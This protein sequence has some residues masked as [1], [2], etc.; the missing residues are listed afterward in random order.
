MKRVAAAALGLVVGGTVAAN[1]ADPPLPILHERV[2]VAVWSW[3]GLYAGTHVG[4]GFGHTQF[5]RQ[6]AAGS[7]YGDSV[8]SPMA[9]GGVQLGYNW[10]MPGTAFVLGVEADAS[11]I[12]S[13]GTNT[14]LASSGFFLSANC[15][16]R[17]SYGGTVAARAGYALGEDA[18]TLLFL[19]SGV[20]ALNQSVTI[21]TNGLWPI[22]A[23][24]S[25]STRVGW[26]AGAGVERAITPAWSVKL[27][28][29]YMDFGTERIATPASYLQVTP[30]VNAYIPQPGGTVDARH[31]A[32]TVKL[33]VNLKLG[34]DSH[35]TWPLRGAIQER[36]GGAEVEVGTRVWYSFGRHQKDLGGT[37]A[38]GFRDF[39]VSRLTYTTSS[40]SGE[41]FARVDT[42]PGVFVKGFVGA[43]RSASGKMHDEDW[44][45][46][47]A[48]VPYSNT[49]SSP[50]KETLAYATFDAGYALFRGANAKVG[51]FIGYNYLRDNNSAFGC[52]QIATPNSVCTPSIPEST[53]V[54]TQNNDWHSL[55]LGING[56]VALGNGI[57]LTGDAAYLPYVRFSGV[58]NHL[59]RTDVPDTVSKEQGFG[60]GVQLEA[61][62]A[63]T[64]NQSFS[65]GAGGRYWAMWANSDANTNIFGTSC[66]CQTLPSRTER[67]G[68]FLQASYKFNVLK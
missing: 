27:E 29:D 60:Q 10:Q 44:L 31:N 22:S 68:G 6:P 7:I 40:Y 54:I 53:L 30:G 14:C 4:G 11:V 45:I 39:L 19:K 2:P 16:V 28:Y 63:Y 8:R 24:S 56:V 5:T 55:R 47:G 43:G 1:A 57:T 38:S 13:D 23:A 65:V 25:S 59:L 50:V 20:A 18:R 42:D 32:H 62:L 36:T 17:Q 33:G 51:A 12:G 49:L 41:A 67:Y 61:L 52:A 66:P 37:T 64:F 48:T 9:M 35:A 21:T 58:D 15:H 26:T 3:T 34:E 46:F